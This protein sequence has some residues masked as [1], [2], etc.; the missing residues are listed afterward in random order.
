[1]NSEV[2]LNKV[3]PESLRSMSKEPQSEQPL[4]QRW[5]T[6]GVKAAD[7]RQNCFILLLD[8][9]WRKGSWHPFLR[10]LL[11]CCCVTGNHTALVSCGSFFGPNI[12]NRH[13]LQQHTESVLNVLVRRSFG[14]ALWLVLSFHGRLNQEHEAPNN[15]ILGSF[16]SSYPSTT[17]RQWSHEEAT[18]W[19]GASGPKSKTRIDFVE[20]DASLS[21]Q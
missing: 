10:L 7:L 12:S 1:M 15:V 14:T 11:F 19:D 6:S 5:A 17:V 18:C 3:R 21:L 13:C 16:W 9:Q 2:D 20:A 8:C 4:P